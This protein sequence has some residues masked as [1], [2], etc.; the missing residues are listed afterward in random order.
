[1]SNSTTSQPTASLTGSHSSDRFRDPF[2]GFS[3]LF[4]AVVGIM[5]LCFL[6]VQANLHG[7]IWQL[8]SVAV[9]GV[10]MILMFGS[11]ALYHL[12]QGSDEKIL[13]LKR[14]DHMAIFAM[15]A[16]TYTPICM[17]ALRDSFGWTLLLSLIHI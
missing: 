7:D 15:I 1:M 12:A 13:K 6:V 4:G 11:S 8:I 2:S 9:F 5:A 16:G 17:I 3:H 14:I 10:C